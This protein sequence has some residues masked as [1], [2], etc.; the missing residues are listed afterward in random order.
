MY[1]MVDRLAN[2]IPNLNQAYTAGLMTAPMVVIELL[3]MWSM[4]PNRRVNQAVLAASVALLAICW[5]SIRAQAA[6]TDRQFMIPH[7]AGAILICKQTELHDAELERLCR[8]IVS[9][10]QEEIDFMKTKL[11]AAR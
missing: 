7:H 11:S 1:A 4:Y 10:Q 5:T 2:A 8:T 9:S 3:V 6:V